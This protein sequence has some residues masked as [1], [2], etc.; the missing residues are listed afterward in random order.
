MVNEFVLAVMITGKIFF[1]GYDKQIALSTQVLLV[2]QCFGICNKNEK[3]LLLSP[4]LWF[5]LDTKRKLI[6]ILQHTVKNECHAWLCI[7]LLSW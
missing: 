4:N 5:V 6:K 3:C 7:F 2:I 1:T